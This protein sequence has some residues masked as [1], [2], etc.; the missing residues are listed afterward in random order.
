MSYSNALNAQ[1]LAE[2]VAMDSKVKAELW[3]RYLEVGSRAHDA[4]SMFESDQ[5]R[6]PVGNS[7]SGKS[8][9][10]VRRRDLKAQGGDK[11]NFT[12]ISAPGGPGVI[13]ERTLKGSESKSKFKTYYVTVDWHRDAVAFT[14]KQIAFMATGNVLQETTAE[15]LKLKMGLWKQN[16]MMV[17]LINRGSGNTYRPNGRAT[18]NALSPSDTLSMELS[19]SAKARLNTMGAKPISQKMGA[20]G[21]VINGFLVFASEYAFLPIRND[22]GYQNAIQTADDRG[23]GNALFTGRL[24]K[25]QGQNFFEH[26]VTDQDWDDYVGSP[27]QPKMVI[28]ASCGFSNSDAAGDCVLKASATNATSLYTQFFNGYRYEFTE[29]DKLGVD[30]TEYY[31]WACNPDGTVAFIAYTGSTHNNGNRITVLKILSGDDINDASHGTSTKGYST[32]GALT[33]GTTST[34]AAHIITLG[35]GNN[36]STDWT[37]TDEVQ[38]GAVVFPANSYGVPV[39]HGFI[40]G[41]SAACRAYGAIEMNGIDQDDDYSF[42]KGKGYEMVFG[43]APTIN[44]NGVTNGYL[45]LEFAIEHEGYPVPSV[46]QY[47]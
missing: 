24:V 1:T 23:E 33:T 36:L 37:Y 43:Q 11:V 7:N 13:G 4:F 44:T 18:R 40:F 8:G 31:A 5:A 16:D 14:K 10:F 19:V 42:V 27:I 38:D 3:A 28:G 20:N 17:G 25:W 32:V 46:D 34:T 35:T 9:V 29:D 47:A 26:I 21:D 6:I 45:L 22:S 30:T 2:A 15:L 39:G 12:V 41:A